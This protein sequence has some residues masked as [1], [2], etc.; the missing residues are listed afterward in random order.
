[1]RASVYVDGFNL[2]YGS[3]RGTKF[4]WLDIARMCRLLLP[5]EQI[6]RIRYCTAMVSARR[7]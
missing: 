3:I 4:H 6:V 5:H 1:M 2:Y 7:C